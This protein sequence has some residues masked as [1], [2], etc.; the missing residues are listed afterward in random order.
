MSI[1]TYSHITPRL[2]NAYPV[3][4]L[5]A[6]GLV[7]SVLAF[8]ANPLEDPTDE[9]VARQLGL[10]VEV[11]QRL[12]TDR[13][14]ANAALLQL[15]KDKLARALAKLEPRPDYPQ[16]AAMFRHLR[17]QDEKGQ[18]TAQSIAKAI[19]EVAKL[20]QA[21]PA[22]PDPAP[23]MAPGAA[24]SQATVAGIPAGPAPAASQ[25]AV[26]RPLNVAGVDS[27]S[28]TWMGPGN[29]GGRTRSIL[30]HPTN[31]SVMWLGSVGGGIWK[32][33]NSGATWAPLADF[34]GSLAVSTLALDP[35]NADTLYAGTGEG[36]YNGDALR[37][38]GIFKSTNGGTTWTQLAATA[39]ANFFWVNRLAISHNG[40]VLLAAT[41]NG[42]FRSTN[43][44][45]SWTAVAAPMN[46]EILDARFH[47]TDN[48]RCIAGG[49]NGKVFYSA[50]GGVSW[51]SG[52]GLPTVAGFGGRV[53]LTYAKANPNTVY[54]S[55]DNSS[56]EVYRS[57]DGGQSYA[58]RNTGTNYLGGQGWYDNTIWAG[59][60]TNV[61]LVVVGGL[62]LYRSMDGGTTFTQISQWWQAPAS[63]HADHHA[64]VAHPNYNGSTNKIVYFGNDGGIYQANNVSTVQGTSGWASLN[65][66]YGVTQFYGAAGNQASGRIVAGAQDNGTIRFTPPPSVGSNSW[67]TMYGGDGGY[68]AADP[69]D[70]NFFY[71]EYVYL[72][73]HRSTNAGAS[74]SYITNGLGDAGS[75]ANFI[76]P[77]ILDPNNS[78]TMLA[79]GSR[80][81]RS[82]NVKA[83]TPAWSAIKPAAAANISAIAVH[84]GSG[85]SSL[86]WVGHNDGKLFKTTNGTAASPTWNAVGATAL[87]A[88]YCT[89]IVIDPTNANRVY[90]TFGG[91][92]PGNLWRTND[93]GLTW[94]NITGTLPGAP[95]YSLAIHPQHANFLYAGSEM[96]LFASNNGGTTWSPTNEGPAN[97]S[98]EELFW[99]GNSSILIAVTHGRG[100]FQI[101]LSHAS[102]APPPP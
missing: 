58:R 30:V 45:V 20:Q 91:F 65:H 10:S 50:N 79:G 86:I 29:I 51:N 9:Q 49:R 80:L 87:P 19:G 26:M 92:S 76:A 94:S 18:V 61:N 82:V 85:G 68:C 34:M 3:Y 35:T 27:H 89:R 97:C 102:P 40:L 93:G 81:W 71:G 24:P 66:S 39:N 63:A 84:K 17:K 98:V 54:A 96:G 52:T 73:I 70:P 44:G 38:A 32:T 5:G 99:L 48:S 33:V 90:V 69:A 72:Q 15:P 7:A 101:D 46:I 57:T 78:N 11:V 28:W 62:D 43:A 1:V 64:I 42:V 23:P 95:V 100:M 74:S 36:F 2:K 13:G 21:A 67:T 53:E 31:A 88:R 12:H 59:D 37:G 77:F 75:N 60:P 14:L 25:P 56:G 8:A 6:L 47:P 22:N 4:A 83:S 55:L 16:E 41:R